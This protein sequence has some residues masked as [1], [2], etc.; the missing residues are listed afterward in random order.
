MFDTTK[1]YSKD[2][3]IHVSVSIMIPDNYH[4]VDTLYKPIYYLTYRNPFLK[5]K[6]YEAIVN[7][8]NRPI[9]AIYP[10]MDLN[11]NKLLFEAFNSD[12]NYSY[13]YQKF[14]VSE[15]IP[16]LEK[17]YRL[18]SIALDKTIAGDLGSE[19]MSL[20]MPLDFPKSFYEVIS[21]N[22]NLEENF[23]KLMCDLISKFNPNI[24]LNISSKNEE[25]LN[26]LIKTMIELGSPHAKKT[27]DLTLLDYLKENN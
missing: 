19:Y 26:Y 22:L 20:L 6:E 21:L 5:D 13:L 10:T 11:K 23:K 27:N 12:Y 4:K 17:Y 18:S 3:K 7:K 8:T 2:L 1:Y 16:T 25:N 9:V 24:K 14:I 15:L